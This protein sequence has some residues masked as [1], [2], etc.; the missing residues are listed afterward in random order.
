MCYPPARPTVLTEQNLFIAV[1]NF[2][3]DFQKL[4]RLLLKFFWIEI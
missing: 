3:I 1:V 4:F 2:V